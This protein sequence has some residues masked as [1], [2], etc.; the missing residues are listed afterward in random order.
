MW[1]RQKENTFLIIS[2]HFLSTTFDLDYIYFEKKMFHILVQKIYVHFRPSPLFFT[3]LIY[4]P[5][6]S[7][8][9]P[10]KDNSFLSFLD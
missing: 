7:F 5:N 10:T 8:F 6:I 3:L 4:K 9:Q 1:R 2:N